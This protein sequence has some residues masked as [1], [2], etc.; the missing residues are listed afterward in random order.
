VPGEIDIILD[1]CRFG[2]V[3]FLYLSPERTQTDLFR[4]RL[5]MMNVSLLVVD[6]V[7]CISQWGYDFRPAYLMI[8][9]LRE[10]LPNVPT[11]ALTASATPDVK[12]DIIQK[13]GLVDPVLVQ[14]SF[15]RSNLSYS[16][17]PVEDKET[18]LL[19]ILTRVA[20]SCI[21]YVGTRKMAQQVTKLLKSHKISCDFYH[22]GLDTP[23]RDLKQDQWVQNAIRV[24]VATNAFGMGVDKPDVRLVIHWD[25]PSDLESYYQEAGRAGR[26]QKNAFA[27]IIYTPDDI[28]VLSRRIE[29]SYPPIDYLRKVYHHLGNFYQMAVGTGHLVSFDFDLNQFCEVYKLHPTDCYQALKKLEEQGVIQLSEAFYTPSR[30]MILLDNKELYKFQVANIHYEAILK[31]LLRIYGGELYS[32]FCYIQEKKLSSFLKIDP[33][34]VAKDL[35]GLHSRDIIQ[36]EPQKDKPQLVFLIPRHPPAKLPLDIKMLKLKKKIDLKKVDR[37]IYYIETKVRCRTQII[38]DYFGEITDQE[39]GICDFCI[40]KKKEPSRFSHLDVFRPKILDI[41]KQ[42]SLLPLELIKKID[43]E[44]KEEILEILR[45]MLENQELAYNE[46]GRIIIDRS[47]IRKS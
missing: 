31:S 1:N 33:S 20:G 46:A 10:L 18:K 30:V 24:I 17:L 40:E 5:K 35:A 21:I 41:A 37:I 7:H 34:Q 11:L 32:S 4:T 13:L 12:D 39:C 25:I 36:Y 27:I 42:E 43:S 47:R 16:V 45:S 23:T 28:K 14:K 9:S 44:K 3:K 19:E 2:K 22:G 15:S 29:R 6:E 38:Q 8:S 26:D